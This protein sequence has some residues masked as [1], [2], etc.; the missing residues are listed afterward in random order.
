MAKKRL[1]TEADL[2][3]VA[4][5]IVFEFKMFQEGYRRVDVAGAGS[6][7]G[8]NSSA[9]N[10]LLR[11]PS[12]PKSQQPSSSNNATGV[13]IPGDDTARF[14]NLEATLIHFR[15]LIEFFFTAKENGNLVL[16]HHFVGSRKVEPKWAEEYR[17][18]C[19]NLL[20]HLTYQRS[21]LRDKNLHHWPDVLQKCELLDQEISEFLNKLPPERKVW[22]K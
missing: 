12:L 13:T 21:A 14:L 19:N 11:E 16:A 10:I 17:I 3:A 4:A 20:A 22:F 9:A 6:P 8:H 15:N 18:R 5:H 2:E 1:R 7:I